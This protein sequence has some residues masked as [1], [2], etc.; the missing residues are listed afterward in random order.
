MSWIEYVRAEIDWLTPPA[1]A[2]RPDE[3]VAP[4]EGWRRMVHDQCYRWGERCWEDFSSFFV[5]Q[6][7]FRTD[8]CHCR[9]TYTTEG[10]KL[11]LRELNADWVER[12][13][14]WDANRG[15]IN[16]NG[17]M[18]IYLDAGN[19]GRRI[20]AFHV[21]F[22]GCGGTRSEFIEYPNG[23]IYTGKP[24]QLQGYRTQFCHTDSSWRFDIT[25]P[26]DQLGGRPDSGDTWR[27]N[28]VSN[29]AVRR[30]RQVAW[31]QGYEYHLDVAR[32]GVIVFE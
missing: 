3:A 4:D 6:N 23:H 22:E 27:L 14:V 8:V 24:S 10:L 2:C 21:W 5:R 25:I 30:N 29:P 19:T 31:C 1:M 7:F 28:V 9:A 16:Q 26:W 18:R 15:T 20:Q 13:A 11:S 12:K 32:L 17:F